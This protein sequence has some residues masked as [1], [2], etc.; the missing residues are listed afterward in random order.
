MW[1][2]MC[3]PKSTTLAIISP[4]YIEDVL[5][6]IKTEKNEREYKDGQTLFVK[7]AKTELSDDNTEYIIG[8]LFLDF[9][10]EFT[11]YVREGEELKPKPQEIPRTAKIT[12][13]YFPQLRGS[14]ELN[15][16]L[17]IPSKQKLAK[18]LG[19]AI[20]EIVGHTAILS[21]NFVFTSGNEGKIRNVFDDIVRIRGEDIMDAFLTDVSVGGTQLYDS[22]E[23]GKAFTGEIRYIGVSIN[24]FWFLVN[25]AGK[26]TTYQ[27]MDDAD[28]I[29][30]SK[31]IIKKMLSVGAVTTP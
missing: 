27:M 25:R 15:H 10:D 20:N 11:T 14:D 31:I 17:I 13:A 7:S 18:L 26:I 23:Y 12:Y 1:W 22:D 2:V 30:Y 3:M 28:F 19:H 29:K 8:E 5:D 21:V 16:V 24:D 4:D 6:V 9:V